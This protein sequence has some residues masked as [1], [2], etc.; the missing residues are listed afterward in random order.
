MAA[1]AATF[2]EDN[3]S[4]IVNNPENV[5]TLQRIQDEMAAGNAVHRGLTPAGLDSFVTRLDCDGD[6]RFL[7]GILYAGRHRRFL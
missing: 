6:A 5:A 2:T 3:R 7:G 1:A 4:C